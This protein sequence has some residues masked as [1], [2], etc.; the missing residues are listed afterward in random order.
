MG[1]RSFTYIHKRVRFLYDRRSTHNIHTCRTLSDGKR[2]V[3]QQIAARIVCLQS[4]YQPSSSPRQT[5]SYYH[6]INSWILRVYLFSCSSLLFIVF[7]HRLL[8]LLPT[9]NSDPGSHSRLFFPL[10]ATVRTCLHFYR[11]KIS[12]FF[13]PRRL[14]SNCA[15]PRFKALSTIRVRKR[16]PPGILNALFIFFRVMGRRGL[17]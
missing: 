2:I 15:Y 8:S 7:A 5:V 6:Y 11:E 13:F 17:H 3:L 4:S 12:A 9:R 16:H 14:A 10:P 1:C